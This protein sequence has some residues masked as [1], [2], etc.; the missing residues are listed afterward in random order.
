[1]LALYLS[2]ISDGENQTLFEKIYNAYRK[3]KANYALS[4]M[5]DHN[6]AEDVV[7]EVFLKIAV[8]YMD[9]ISKI[10][11]EIDM[12]NYLLKAVKNTSLNQLKRKSREN[13]SLDS[14][15]DDDSGDSYIPVKD[16]DF[17]DELIDKFE[18]E[19]L[20]RKIEI[21]DEKYREVLY[22]RFVV[23]LSIVDTAKAVDRS[24][25]TTKKQLLRGKKQLM[26]LLQKED[27]GAHVYDA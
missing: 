19:N 20:L 18:Y 5:H 27:S 15:V 13:I 22:Y 2:L 21:L 25:Q 1:M 9:V 11:N 12:R 8:K 26:L 6:D 3:Q 4:I 16:I 23:G 10:N 17:V 24:V 7:H 14:L